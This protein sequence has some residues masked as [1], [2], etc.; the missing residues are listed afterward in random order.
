MEYIVCVCV[1]V[2]VY[3]YIYIYECYLPKMAY[4]SKS[5]LNNRLK[6]ISGTICQ[7]KKKKKKPVTNKKNFDEYSIS[8]L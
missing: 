4:Y 2:C 1:C 3:I 7:K 8:Y 5:F 6:A